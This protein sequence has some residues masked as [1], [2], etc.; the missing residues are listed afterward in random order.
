MTSFVTMIKT[1]D[2]LLKKGRGSGL[3]FVASFL[4]LILIA[5][6]FY[7]VS[8]I[9]QKGVIFY[10]LGLS[11]IVFATLFEAAYQIYRSLLDGRTQT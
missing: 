11:V 9:S 10:I 1:I 2:R 7:I 4:K 6:L 8:L 5:V 3:F